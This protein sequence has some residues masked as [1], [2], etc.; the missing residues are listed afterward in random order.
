MPH[1]RNKTIGFVS[2]ALGR[3]IDIPAEAHADAFAK[4][5]R[6]TDTAYTHRTHTPHPHTPHHT[7]TVSYTHRITHLTRRTARRIT[8]TRRT[9]HAAHT[10]Q[11]L[12]LPL[13]TLPLCA[14]YDAAAAQR[15]AYAESSQRAARAHQTPAG[16]DAQEQRGLPL[17]V[18]AAA[19]RAMQHG[20]LAIAP[21]W[22][23][24]LSGEP[25]DSWI[26]AA[27]SFSAY[28]HLTSVWRCFPHP[29]WSHTG[30]LF[31]ARVSGLW[32]E[33]LD[34]LNVTPSGRPYEPQPERM[35][36]LVLPASLLTALPAAVQ[37]VPAR[38]KPHRGS[39]L[40]PSG[41]LDE[42]SRAPRAAHAALGFKRLHMVLHN[43]VRA[44]GPRSC[45]ACV[46]RVR[47]A[48]PARA[49]Y[50]HTQHVH[51]HVHAH[52]YAGARRG[53]ARPPRRHPRRTV[54]VCA[55]RAGRRP[56]GESR[57]SA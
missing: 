48:C 57:C 15:L 47:C 33:R 22:L 21:T 54:R 31:T 16:G 5:A 44:D 29:C 18:A 26:G 49:L 13:L 25:E 28:V 20:S 27:P 7:D 9:T 42:P 1:E 37:H 43:L 11:V 19:G 35:R 3:A 6:H 45:R 41:E 30:R 36:A 23:A 32:D 51:A 46:P 56:P 24:S 4:E 10:L 40:E 55:R 2:E 8:R 34:A 14:P 52:A 50:T 53:A 38:Q 39:A 17:S 12:R